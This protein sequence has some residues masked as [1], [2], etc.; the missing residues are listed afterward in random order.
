MFDTNQED[1]HDDTIYSLMNLTIYFYVPYCA[2][3]SVSLAVDTK[4]RA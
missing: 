1:Y 2:Y 4:Q 3:V